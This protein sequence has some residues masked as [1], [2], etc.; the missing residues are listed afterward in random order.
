MKMSD[1]FRREY[2]LH[3]MDCAREYWDRRLFRGKVLEESYPDDL[4]V[5][6]KEW[7]AAEKELT[8][9]E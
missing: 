9:E 5:T 3:M 2:I 8:L 6:E 1:G 7:K 4:F